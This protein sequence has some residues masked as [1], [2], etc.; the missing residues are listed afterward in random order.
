MD[1]FRKEKVVQLDIVSTLLDPNR[2]HTTENS[3]SKL[4]LN[5]K[6]YYKEMYITK[7]LALNPAKLPLLKTK[8]P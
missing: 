2:L 6:D 4:E 7:H 3:M 1:P 5:V 8:H